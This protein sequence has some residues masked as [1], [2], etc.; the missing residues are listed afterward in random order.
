MFDTLDG[1]QYTYSGLLSLFSHKCDARACISHKTTVIYVAAEKKIKNTCQAA[2]K[3]ET[4]KYFASISRLVKGTERCGRTCRIF[5][6]PR[7]EVGWT[8]RI[9]SFRKRL[10]FK[11]CRYRKPLSISQRESWCESTL[12]TYFEGMHTPSTF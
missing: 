12:C 3:G 8:G 10:H 5:W 1:F 2:D 11:K 6:C 7:G 9:L 4:I